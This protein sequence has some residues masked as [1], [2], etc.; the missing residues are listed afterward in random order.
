MNCIII[1]DDH[2]SKKLIEEF[3]NKT[4]NLVLLQAFDNAMDAIDFLQSNNSIDLIFL[5]IEMPEMTGIDFM[6]TVEDPPLIIIV[7]AKEKYALKAFDHNVVDYLLKPITYS[8]F[9][10]AINKV[11]TRFVKTK[12]I[13]ENREEIFIKKSSSLIRL[14]Y[15]NILWIEALENYVVFNTFSDKFTVHFTMKAIEKKMPTHI[16]K[17]VHRS[18]IVNINKIDIIE[19]N[20][21]LLPVEGGTKIIPI[22]KSYKDKLLEDLNLMS[23]K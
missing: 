21:V 23:S 7:S 11:I 5:D 6:N 20:S 19:D 4:N 10:K 22:G 12:G 9:F 3:I 14:Q 2:L 17:R 16:F 18:Y 8:R 13:S 1:E 15:D